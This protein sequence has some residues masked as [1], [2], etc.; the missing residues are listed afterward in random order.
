MVFPSGNGNAHEVFIFFGE[1]AEE[2]RREAKAVVV[3]QVVPPFPKVTLATDG[4]AS[5]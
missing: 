5:Y 2:R 1:G 4:N 3:W